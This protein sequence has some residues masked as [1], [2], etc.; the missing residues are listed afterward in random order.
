[1]FMPS[2]NI[3]KMSTIPKSIYK[4]NAIPIKIPIAYFTELEQIMLNFVWSEKRYWIAKTIL[5]KNKAGG[6]MLPDFKVY[7]KSI[8]TKK[9][10]TGTKTD[11]SM[12][13]N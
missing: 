9:Y 8:V 13:Q 11:R 10:G 6:I 7:Y 5:R 1:M 12:K 2:K 3:V 4:F